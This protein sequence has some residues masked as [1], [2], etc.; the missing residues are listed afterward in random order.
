M[1]A[2]FIYK[3]DVDMVF[4]QEVTRPEVAAIQRYMAYTNLG[5]EGRGTAILTKDGVRVDNIKHIPSGRGIAVDLQGVWYINVYAP[6]GAERKPERE[7]FFNTD[8]PLILPVTPK[9]LL[10]AGDFNCIINSADSTGNVPCS[11]ALDKIVK[12]LGLHNV[13]NASEARHGFYALCPYVA[14]ASLENL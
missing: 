3:Q 7:T 6:S 12:W 10:L 14:N 8:L 2:E 4:L 11:K 5:T 1:L 13:W 9:E